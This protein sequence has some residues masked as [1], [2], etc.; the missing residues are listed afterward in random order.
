M[1]RKIHLDYRYTIRKDLLSLHRLDQL[2]LHE[3]LRSYNRSI[4]D[5]WSSDMDQ[6]SDRNASTP[7]PMQDG[8]VMRDQSRFE[9]Q[10]EHHSRRESSV[11]SNRKSASVMR[12][13]LESGEE[14]VWPRE[15]IRPRE[16]G[17]STGSHSKIP[18][19]PMIPLKWNGKLSDTFAASVDKYEAPSN[20]VYTFKR[21]FAVKTLRGR[22]HRHHRQMTANELSAMKDIRHPHITALLG[23]FEHQERLSIMIFPITT[24]SL[25]QFLKS[26]SRDIRGVFGENHRS[27]VLDQAV[28]S[29]NGRRSPE[30]SNGSSDDSGIGHE[31]RPK[32]H[33][34]KKHDAWPLKT[35]PEY[36]VELLRNYFVCLSQ[37]LSYLH[38]SRVSHNDIKTTNIL[39]DQS[40]AVLLS[41]FT[42]SKPFGQ[43]HQTEYTRKYASPETL[44]GD[45]VVKDGASDVFSL[46]CVFLELV[47]VLLGHDIKE[48]PNHTKTISSLDIELEEAY[49]CNLRKIYSWIDL[50]KE[51]HS[52]L[53]TESYI[54]DGLIPIRSMLNE[55]PQARPTARDLWMQFRLISPRICPDCDPRHSKVWR[56]NKDPEQSESLGSLPEEYE[57]LD[58]HD[59]ES[60]VS[61]IVSV[62]APSI[63]S[64]QTH[65]STTA[66]SEDQGAPEEFAKVLLT[67]EIMAPL[68]VTALHRID[69]EKLER[70]LAR[71]L[72][73][74]ANDLRGEATTGL[75]RTAV[76][77]AR[78]YA[79][80]VASHVCESLDP[81]GSSRYLKMHL[82]PEQAIRKEENIERYLQ[83]VAKSN[84]HS[85]VPG[86]PKAL[87]DIPVKT[88]YVHSDDS[89]SDEADRPGIS[90]LKYVEN[91]MTKSQAYAKLK[92]NFRAFAAPVY[93]PKHQGRPNRVL[94]EEHL[95]LASSSDDSGGATKNREEQHNDHG[96]T[97]KEV[98]NESNSDD[99]RK[100]MENREE[101][102]VDQDLTEDY[103]EPIASSDG[104]NDRTDTNSTTTDSSESQK[105]NVSIASEEFIKAP[106]YNLSFKALKGV[107]L[108]IA[109]FL[110][111]WEKPLENGFVRVR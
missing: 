88:T 38:E 32:D 99:F 48:L 70:N 63:F 50:L 58:S 105:L 60:E 86:T 79:Q 9:S 85:D 40:E 46:G 30:T 34:I 111:V 27:H 82:L 47:T 52:S 39:I 54:A 49:S 21:P 95:A 90:N 13:F 4:Q 36:K 2:N 56:S 23:A 109:E 71:L 97:K 45:V 33:Q 107:I 72:K 61:S 69:I 98:D 22:S 77:F 96:L 42:I 75:E 89:E 100:T 26:M 15:F 101:I 17:H 108:L 110:G 14:F 62:K 37:G 3:L 81:S 59:D 31:R 78:R 84:T 35:S 28:T 83:Q 12:E 55:D 43:S 73:S 51:K 67:D 68:Y 80:S 64:D 102:Y 6:T 24:C 41:N 65:S 76:K 11:Q 93:E 103:I 53:T 8:L 1:I 19:L 91:F 106:W 10:H 66:V 104:S 57:G 16:E 44:K 5:P 94:E 18:S 92:E 25:K 20:G 7:N 74:Y 87:Q 29:S